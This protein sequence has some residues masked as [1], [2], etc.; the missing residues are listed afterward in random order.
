MTDSVMHAHTFSQ[1]NVNKNDLA[2]SCD[3]LFLNRDL[4]GDG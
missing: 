4:T 1:L 2:K 3:F